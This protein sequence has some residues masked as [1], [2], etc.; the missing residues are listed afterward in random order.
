MLQINF[1]K[2]I[3]FCFDSYDE[4]PG[5]Y[6]GIYR[7]YSKSNKVYDEK[8]KE[9]KKERAAKFIIGKITR[10]ISLNEEF[11]KNHTNFGPS[12]NVFLASINNNYSK[13]FETEY[14]CIFDEVEKSVN[15][16]KKD[17]L[18]GFNLLGV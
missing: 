16:S 9:Y 8:Q 17:I 18:E 13:L 14:H 11:H 4:E 12:F 7:D 2:N 3:I 10:E 5:L 1:I 6:P 15:L